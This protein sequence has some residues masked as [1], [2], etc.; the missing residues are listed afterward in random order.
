[1]KEKVKLKVT[2]IVKF[3]DLE[4]GLFPLTFLPV[5][6]PV[7]PKEKH[8]HRHYSIGILSRF[9]LELKLPHDTVVEAW[10]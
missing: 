9:R 4:Q 3:D 7:L 10:I 5:S 6:T 8:S 2:V 1:M